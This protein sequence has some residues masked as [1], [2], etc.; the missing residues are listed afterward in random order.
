MCPSSGPLPGRF[1]GPR[2]PP[3]NAQLLPLMKRRLDL[4]TGTPVWKAYGWPRVRTSPI[5]GDLR[6]DVLVVGMG[7]SGAMIAEAL[8]SDGHSVTV[9]DRRGAIK[10][11]T[12]ATTAL[13]SSEIDQPLSVLAMKIGRT[14]AERAWMRSR[15][16]IEALRARIADLSIDCDLDERP[17]LYLA[18]SVLDVDGLRAEAQ[19]RR[20]T[21]LWS[22]SCN[23][24]I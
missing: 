21:G 18:G 3:A 10:G 16:A 13:V 17:S 7:I 23:L 19:A 15:L 6:T 1:A 9:V 4:R 2:P 14:K 20:S 5:R 11:S 22:R 24:A 12:A 8:A